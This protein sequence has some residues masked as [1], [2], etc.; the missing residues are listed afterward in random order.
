M[1]AI[2]LSFAIKP[3]FFKNC[4]CRTEI[5]STKKNKN[6]SG[7]MQ[8][9]FCK[10]GRKMKIIIRCNKKEQKRTARAHLGELK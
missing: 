10:L 5:E 7:Y 3:Q 2:P 6:I 4:I 1:E 9:G 8:I